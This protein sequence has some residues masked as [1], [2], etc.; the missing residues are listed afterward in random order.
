MKAG[1]F[2]SA[3]EVVSRTSVVHF[4][5]PEPEG[6]VATNSRPSRVPIGAPAD[7]HEHVRQDET[8]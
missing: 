8:V 3:G 5:S 1:I 6:R 2:L 7:R 4:L